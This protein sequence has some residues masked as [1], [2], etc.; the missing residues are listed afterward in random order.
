MM[1]TLP[2]MKFTKTK[3]KETWQGKQAR[4]DEEYDNKC[5][6]RSK[7]LEDHSKED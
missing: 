7:W 1:T 2:L 5:R 3:K 6:M 4:E